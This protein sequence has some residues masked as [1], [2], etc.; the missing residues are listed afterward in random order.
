MGLRMRCELELWKSSI[1]TENTESTVDGL[2]TL[3]KTTHII[4]RGPWF[5]NFST[6]NLIGAIHSNAWIFF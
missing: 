4:M 3:L 6:N 5:F 1:L 2:E